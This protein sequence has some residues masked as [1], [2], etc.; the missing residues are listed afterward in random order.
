MKGPACVDQ[1]KSR[2]VT[3]DNVPGSLQ[4]MRPI[5]L[6]PGVVTPAVRPNPVANALEGAPRNTGI[7]TT[8]PPE[9]PR[10]RVPRSWLD[11]LSDWWNS[12]G[13]QVENFGLADR[14]AQAR[15]VHPLPGQLDR[16]A[17]V[18][19]NHP[20]ILRDTGI[21]LSTLPWE[22]PVHLAQPQSGPFGIFAHHNNRSG[23][24]LNQGILLH[25]PS[26]RPVTV[27][28]WTTAV[29]TTQEAP[30]RDRRAD[31]VADPDGSQASGPGDASAALA[32]R[33][34]IE[35]AP[36]QV[37]V[38]PGGWLPLSLKGVPQGAE[39]T[40]RLD[41]ETDGP[42][43]TAVVFDEAGTDVEQMVQRLHN[44]RRLPPNPG[45]KVPTE[46]GAPG[47]IIF[48]RV[49][50]IQEGRSWQGQ[51]E[52]EPGQGYRLTGA[53]TE[54]GFVLVGKA[55]NTLGTGQ[56]QAAP[57]PHRYADAAWKAHG[58]YGVLHDLE[59][60]LQNASSGQQRVSFLLD[61]P[62]PAPSLSRAFRGTLAFT[63]KAADG[64][65]R[66]H[67]ANVNQ[68]AGEDASKALFTL[69]LPAGTAT[70]VRVRF[71]YPANATPP[72]VL[73]VRSEPT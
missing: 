71:I 62:T 30:Y 56:D 1:G 21:A 24:T 31:I 42:V 29:R 54:K 35:D 8:R 6:V 7:G 12:L 36:R 60:P 13:R 53:A 28:I 58:N 73:R 15:P 2:Q 61:T 10:P 16:T 51:L 32:L 68:R 43:H 22:G 64:T 34:W 26:D 9:T 48:G 45:D 19:S 18:N 55:S 47:P 44:G 5:R 27:T 39:I 63:W 70:P 40:S 41:L 17:L 38:P 69:D 14:T 25:N 72:H 23:R 66:T 33:Q 57:L 20:E 65:E 50:G 49:A 4:V 37:V 59:V 67:Y 11:K 52:L 46:P 3:H